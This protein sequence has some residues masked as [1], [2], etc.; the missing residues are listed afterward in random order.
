MKLCYEGLKDRAAWEK[1]GVK[2]PGFDWKAMCAETEKAPT[3]V[4]FGAGNIF[5]G[6]IANLQQALLEQE[7]VKGGIV[8]AET[9]DYDIIDRIYD[10]YDSMTLLVSL[11]PDG[12]MKKEVV[13]S[14]AK[15]LRAGGAFPEDM[16][17]LKAIFR[18]PSLQMISFTITEKGYA[19]TNMEGEFFPFVEADFQNGP[20]KCSHAM[21]VVC[22]LLL[23]R[24]NA[25]A[26][27]LAVVSMDNCSHNGEKLRESVVTVAEKWLENGLVD[28]AFVAWVKDETTVSFP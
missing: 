26:A 13:A 23:E 1:T 14:I 5:R 21:S 17:R 20:A 3:W 18:N 8:A 2:L 25:G 15:G 24:F 28:E 19:L 6:F 10:P 9:F 7:L 27:P 22:A 12:S 4:H 16:E 11:L